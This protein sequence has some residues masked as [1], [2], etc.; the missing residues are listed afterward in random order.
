MIENESSVY[1][2][3]LKYI[4]PYVRMDYVIDMLQ[5]NASS[6]EI[7]LRVEEVEHRFLYLLGLTILQF[8]FHGMIALR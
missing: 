1:Q 4:C 8:K 3:V 2:N 7:S 5:T 6:E